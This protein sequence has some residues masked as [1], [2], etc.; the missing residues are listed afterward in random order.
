MGIIFIITIVLLVLAAKVVANVL[1][2]KKIANIVECALWWM[3]LSIVFP[4][5]AKSLGIIH[6]KIYSWLLI[7]ISPVA[8]ITY[9][10]V[11]MIATSNAPLPYEKLLFTSRE[12]IAAITEIDDFPEFEYINNDRDDWDGITWTR[13]KFKNKDDS[14]LLIEKIERKLSEEENYL[15]YKDDLLESEKEFF[16]GDSIYVLD[17]G[18]LDT[19]YMECPKGIKENWAQ[20]R[21][22]IGEKAFVVRYAG[23]F[24]WDLEYYSNPDSLSIL[25]GVKIPDYKFVN[26]WYSVVGPDSGWSAVLELESKPSKAFLKSLDKSDKWKKLDDGGYKF[27]SEDRKGYLW[28]YVYVDPK[29]KFME[30]IVDTH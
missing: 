12:E 28:E 21:I 23:C 10:V 25:T 30:L 6:K 22:A 16:G 3:T 29:S 19:S 13:N 18:W 5:R 17:R 1:T 27:Y 9:I 7:L 15:W 26:F 8:I 24:P 20:V 2:N 4:F 11:Y 14:K